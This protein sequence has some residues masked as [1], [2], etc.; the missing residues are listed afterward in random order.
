MNAFTRKR[1][2][3]AAF[4]IAASGAL[5]FSLAA[6]SSN[7]GTATDTSSTSSSS[8]AEPSAASTPAASIADLSNGVDT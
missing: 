4:G 6:C 3:K 1:I 7:S 2:T 5:I 8:S